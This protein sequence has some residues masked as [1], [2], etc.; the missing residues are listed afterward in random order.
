MVK[1]IYFNISL[2]TQEL[3]SIFWEVQDNKASYY[4]E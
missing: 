3:L 2:V 1:A 4:F